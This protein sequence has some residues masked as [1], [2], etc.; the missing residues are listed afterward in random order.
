MHLVKE[1]GLFLKRRTSAVFLFFVIGVLLFAV[2]GLVGATPTS[3]A[4]PKQALGNASFSM[5]LQD[6]L[7][8]KKGS[9]SYALRVL[10]V[11][12]GRVLISL[13]VSG[14]VLRFSLAPDKPLNLD[15]TGDKQADGS[16]TLVK[17]ENNVASLK[18]T[19]LNSQDSLGSSSGSDSNISSP[20][21]W[22]FFGGIVVV[23]LLIVLI[24]WFLLRKKNSASSFSG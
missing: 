11:Q 14:N 18:M 6:T 5:K 15:I 2:I 4:L 17:L 22:L 3:F 9:D 8:W 24:G 10:G 1:R 13:N 23:L 21:T 19:S 7:Q 16:I 12:N 20:R